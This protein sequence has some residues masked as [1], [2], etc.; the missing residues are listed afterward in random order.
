MRRLKKNDIFVKLLL[1]SSFLFGTHFLSK[2]HAL[3][4]S[5]N[6]YNTSRL[7]GAY[8]I[9]TF[10]R[11]H[12]WD[13]EVVDYFMYWSPHELEEFTKSKITEHTR[14]IGFSTMWSQWNAR[15][16]SYLN[17]I[18]S[19][20]P[21]I[22]T[23]IGGQQCQMIDAN[24]TYFINGYGENAILALCQYH[25]SNGAELKLDS[26]W[27]PFGKNVLR[28]V[29]YPSAPLKSLLISYEDR[30]YI[31][32]EDWLPIEF[33][34]GCK[35]ECKFCNFPI[36]GVKSDYSR[37]AADLDVHLRELYDKFGV[38]NYYVSDETFNDSLEKMSKFS[39]VVTALPFRPYFS[40]FIRADLMVARKDDKTLLTDLGFFGQYYGIETMNHLTGKSIGKGMAPEKLMPGL[41]ELKSYFKKHGDYRGEISLI[42]G[43]P[44]ETEETVSSSIGWLHSNWKGEA[45]SVW[46]LRLYAD[47]MYNKTNELYHEREKYGYRLSTTPLEKY[48]KGPLGSKMWNWENDHFTAYRACQLAEEARKNMSN[49]DF[50]SSCWSLGEYGCNITDALNVDWHTPH[51]VNLDRISEYKRKKINFV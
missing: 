12:G 30:D 49:G 16:D 43:L 38:K 6:F 3:I 41:L 24:P 15:V 10:L 11:S 29:D 33:S 39:K 27:V 23:I 48:A 35:F 20:Y 7:G 32:S 47:E 26:N 45:A 22:V 50:K 2:N 18:K 5:C 34:R 1:R 19:E 51:V 36:L 42:V 21:D 4:L 28:N 13:I 37:D 9:A 25:W 14:F 40:G 17:W 46:P 44:H 8:R 31:S